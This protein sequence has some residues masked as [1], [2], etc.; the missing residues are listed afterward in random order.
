MSGYSLNYISEAPGVKGKGKIMGWF[1]PEPQTGKE[2]YL[3]TEDGVS[4]AAD[5]FQAPGGKKSRLIVVGPGFAKTKNGYPITELCQ[6][7]TRFGDVLSLDFRGVGNSGGRYSFGAHEYKDLKPFL[8]WGR[9]SYRKNILLGLSL[10]SYHSFRAAHDWPH[11]VD[12]ALLVSCP[13]QLEDVLKT[14]GPLRQGWAIVTDWKALAKRLK[15]RANPF[16]R[17]GNPFSP[18]PK[19]EWLA[20]GVS[21]PLSFLVGGKDRLVVKDLSRKV[22]DRASNPKTWTEIPEG[23]HAEF[24]YLENEKKFKQW[25]KMNLNGKN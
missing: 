11:L 3:T 22:Y 9:R 6:Y 15:V 20:P 8:E 5:F 12:Q 19:A 16:F 17:W 24:L 14:L 25:L 1:Y 21:V 18:K 7:L 2:I 23:N 4:I 13:S 10:G